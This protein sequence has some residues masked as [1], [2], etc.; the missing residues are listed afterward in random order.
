MLFVKKTN[1][2]LKYSTIEL[3]INLESEMLHGIIITDA[4]MASELV[5]NSNLLQ[6][7]FLSLFSHVFEGYHDRQ[8]RRNNKVQP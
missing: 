7:V 4:C 2:V 3:N 5:F 1:L 6:N 8:L